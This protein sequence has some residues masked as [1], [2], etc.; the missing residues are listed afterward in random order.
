MLLL[1]RWR[2]RR[3]WSRKDCRHLPRQADLMESR[4]RRLER[5][6]GSFCVKGDVRL[7]RGPDAME[8]NCQLACHCNNRLVLGLFATS[9]GQMQTP[10]PKCRVFPLWTQYMVG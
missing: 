7:L 1:G 10:L 2:H 4:R 9:G 5:S 3:W 6:V 8:Q